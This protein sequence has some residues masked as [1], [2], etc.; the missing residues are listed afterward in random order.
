V[1]SAVPLVRAIPASC[2]RREGMTWRACQ[3]LKRLV[4]VGST[5]TTTCTWPP[6]W[7]RSAGLWV[8]HGANDRAGRSLRAGP[9]AWAQWRASGSRTGSDA[10]GL[11]RWLGGRG[12]QVVEGNRPDRQQRRRRRGTSDPVDAEAAARAALAGEDVTTQGRRRHGG[13]AAG[14][15]VARRS[16]V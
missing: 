12:D 13:D 8:H 4:T 7:T 2:M 3:L 11:A 15:P 6:L 5:A 1:L 16:A 9:V 10:A 14:V